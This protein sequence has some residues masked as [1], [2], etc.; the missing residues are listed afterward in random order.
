MP[1]CSAAEAALTAELQEARRRIAEL[2]MA[3]GGTSFCG[4]LVEHMFD[5][6]SLLTP[7]G[8]HLDVNP[9]LCEMTGFSREELVGA[10]PPHPYW[11]PEEGAAI[12]AAFQKTLEGRTETF[13]LT[14]MRKNGERFPVLVTP[15][16]L[17]DA[18]GAMI[19]AFALVKDMTALR[20]VEA[21]LAESE[22][23]FRLTFDQAPIGAALVGLDFRFRRV[24]ARFA[25]MA[26]YSMDE[27]LERGFPDITHPDDVAADV[28][29]VKRLAA[30]EIDEYARQKRYVRK[31]G[32]V[33]W[34]DV[35]VRPVAGEDGRPLA[36]IAMVADVTERRTAELALRES[37]ERLR[38]LL[39]NMNDAVYVHEL[40]A[41]SP[42]RFVD[43]NARA[44]E[45]LG[46]SREELLA[47]DVGAIDVP[48]QAERLP[49]IMAT[50]REGGR[51]VFET[52]HLTRQGR[53]L[54]VEVSVRKLDIEGVTTV[55]SVAR[56]ITERRAAEAET[57]KAQ[58]L[59]RET[60][61][62]SKLGGW[63]YDVATERIS[64]TDEVYRIHGVEPGFDVNDV[65]HNIGFYLPEDQP[66]IAAAFRGV[67]ESGVPYD[68]DLQFR[69]ADGRQLW[70]RTMARAITEGGRVVRVTGNIVDITERKAAEEEIRRL[71]A[72]LEQRVVSRT[73]QLDASTRELEAL[74]YSIAHDVRAPLRTIDGFSAAVMEDEGA[75][76]QR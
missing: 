73:E 72:E 47:M 17:R 27:L 49:A 28:V 61:E 65:D 26:G 7:D 19:S 57:A 56:D 18:A 25:Q 33:A 1:D 75:R 35:V 68:L 64:W 48:E 4:E 10:G 60:Q 62:I 37:G 44:C 15:S 53:R 70:V 50:L 69:T 29:E 12:Q 74:A 13:P 67:V 24:N 59:L 23:L 6:F 71:N 2:E 38:L 8:V 34:G 9:A 30:G 14:F 41:E 51:A 3:G 76:P 16:V 66:A 5:G 32:G 46:Y 21:A 42:G 20:E 31:D 40:R 63:E 36:F 11:P 58:R 54:P 43:V 55:L 39:Q 22:R 52:E 45:L